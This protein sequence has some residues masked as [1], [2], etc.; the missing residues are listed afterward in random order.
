MK[1]KR[2]IRLVVALVILLIGAFL[3]VQTLTLEIGL[4][5]Y[6]SDYPL[7]AMPWL[8]AAMVMNPLS[9]TARA[10]VANLLIHEGKF[11]DA[12]R[13]ILSNLKKRPNNPQNHNIM[14]IILERNMEFE[15]ALEEYQKAVKLDPEY[16][17]ALFNIGYLQYKMGRLDEG[18]KNIEQ[19][20]KLAPEL[21]KSRDEIM[22]NM[23]P[24]PEAQPFTPA[25]P[26]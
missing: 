4:A 10:S 16:A 9:N 2:L 13:I 18:L 11:E 20:V 1:N 14:G 19:A 23:Q 8:R 22:K 17:E 26:E 25:S 12:E 15:K 24:P 5:R 7:S 3:I 21:E 6:R